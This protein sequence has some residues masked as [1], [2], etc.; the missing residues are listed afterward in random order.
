[1]N[2]LDLI[3][4][5]AFGGLAAGAVHVLTGPDHLAAVVPLAAQARQRGERRGFAVG[6]LWGLGHGLGVVLLGGLGALLRSAIDV[7]IDAI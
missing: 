2:G 5:A 4:L 6:V 3:L 1:M 7:D